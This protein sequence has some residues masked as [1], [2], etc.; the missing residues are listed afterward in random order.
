MA[1]AATSIY[2]VDCERAIEKPAEWGEWERKDWTDE[3]LQSIGTSKLQRFWTATKRVVNLACLATPVVVLYPLSLVSTTA[4]DWTWS[5]SLFAIEQAGPTF[6]KLVQWATTRQDLFSPE[7]CRYF[8]KLRDD[9]KGHSWRETQTIL[10]KELGELS[11]QLDLEDTPI[12]SGCIAQVY[13][14]TIREA[15][16]PYPAGTQVAA[17]I[18]HPGIFS[19]V[20]VDFYIMAKVA[21]FLEGL[22]YLNLAMLSIQ[23]TVRQFRDIMLPQLNLTLEA[24][25]LRRF[26][27]DFVD[28]D[29]VFFP[30]P[31]DDLTSRRVLTETFMEGTPILEFVDADEATRKE[32]AYLGL[33]TTLKQIFAHDHIHGDLHPGNLLASLEGGKVRLKI[34]D[35]GLVV[36]MGP[37]QHVNLIKILGS[38]VR[39]RGREAGQLMVDMGST[40]QASAV[41]IERFVSGIQAIVVDD[42]SNNFVEKVGD[43]IADICYLACRNHV[44][45]EASFVNAALAVEIVEGIASAL[46]PGTSLVRKLCSLARPSLILFTFFRNQRVE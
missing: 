39:R 35:C 13:R 17:K 9:T 20:C 5:Y 21:R 16:G 23:D 37:E 11:T 4:L 36:E 46:Y 3:L 30:Y 43:Y 33:E 15:F 34:L 25:N 26:N 28:D 10:R 14:G 32:L 44:K 2:R 6:I 18:Q 31:L 42:E 27:R 45:L 19:K 40:A 24:N 7:F 12:G 1:S 22:P 8:G 38:F 41:D 29:R